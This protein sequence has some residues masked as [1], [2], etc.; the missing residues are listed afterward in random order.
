MLLNQGNSAARHRR[1]SSVYSLNANMSASS[2]IVGVTTPA[3]TGPYA[4]PS[5]VMYP[6]QKHHPH[7]PQSHF[8]RSLEEGGRSAALTTP[9]SSARRRD[10]LVASPRNGSAPFGGFKLSLDI[11]QNGRASIVPAGTTLPKPR[12]NSDENIGPSDM[13]AGAPVTSE[14]ESKPLVDDK[15]NMQV[16]E[17]NRVLD[18]LRQMRSKT[19]KLTGKNKIQKG[20]HKQDTPATS[21]RKTEQHYMLP[22]ISSNP[23]PMAP[24]T[25]RSN[26]MAL[27]TGFTPNLG[28]D[29][30]LLDTPSRKNST[31][32]SNKALSVLHNMSPGFH[33]SPKFKSPYRQAIQDE[34]MLLPCDSNQNNLMSSPRREYSIGMGM[35]NNH[36]PPTWDTPQAFTPQNYELNEMAMSGLPHS[37]L[38]P[39]ANSQLL[40]KVNVSSHPV[41]SVDDNIRINSSNTHLPHIAQLPIDD[42]KNEKQGMD[43]DHMPLLPLT[44]NGSLYTAKSPAPM[45]GNASGK[46]DSDNLDNGDAKSAL[47]KLLE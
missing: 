41:M 47:K 19:N 22:P 23:T 30:M 25:P 46:A 12:D 34:T 15:E 16:S 11:G 3:L 40:E 17:A 20:I 6:S 10:S 9:A 39:F 21:K 42:M 26:F 31:Y 45:D 35:S 37:G 4:T 43:S 44:L 32:A 5:S 1:R 8:A 24:S 14:K 27:R 36:T 29:Q 38:T 18:L 2:S 33:F 28:I 13:G 7:V